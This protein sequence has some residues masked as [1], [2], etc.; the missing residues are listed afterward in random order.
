[1]QGRL[2]TG[3][4]P[5]VRAPQT[6]GRRVRTVHTINASHTRYSVSGLAV[7]GVSAAPADQS[8]PFLICLRNTARPSRIN[9]VTCPSMRQK[10]AGANVTARRNGALLR[11]GPSY[12]RHK[13]DAAHSRETICSAIH[14]RR[15][16][17]YGRMA[18]GKL[19]ARIQGPY[20]VGSAVAC[21]QPAERSI[22]R[23]WAASYG[24]LPAASARD[25]AQYEMKSSVR[26]GG[27]R[28]ENHVAAATASATSERRT[29]DRRLTTS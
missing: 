25:A 6:F 17:Q 4:Q 8:F 10:M 11:E 14:T 15:A 23:S 28:T 1:M 26:A 5:S 27:R 29:S 22:D 21:C 20:Q 24:L 12:T 7:R 2:T 13:S 16:G 3:Q 18:I 9:G 19:P